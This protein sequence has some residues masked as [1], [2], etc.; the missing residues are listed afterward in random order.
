[1]IKVASFVFGI[2]SWFIEHFSIILLLSGCRLMRRRI[3][4]A[5]ASSHSD[6]GTVCVCWNELWMCLAWFDIDF[7]VCISFYFYFSQCLH[8]APRSSEGT[9]GR[10]QNDF[11]VI[12]A[13]IVIKT[14][15]WWAYS[16]LYTALRQHTSRTQIQFIQPQHD[17]SRLLRT[18][19]H[20]QFQ[21]PHLV[22]TTYGHEVDTGRGDHAQHAV[23]MVF[24]REREYQQ[25]PGQFV[26]ERV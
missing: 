8:N 3:E 19:C 25:L 24:S 6:V 13:H 17:G 22:Q 7:N 15:K 11:V 21:Y 20:Q 1:M 12:E 23:F 4:V 26:S 16:R 18:K 14:G 9:P 10:Q 5:A 2:R